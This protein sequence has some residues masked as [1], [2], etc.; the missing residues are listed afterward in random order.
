MLPGLGTIKL[1]KPDLFTQLSF[2][3]SISAPEVLHFWE[4]SAGL[5]P[6]QL[7]LGAVTWRQDETHW[8]LRITWWPDHFQALC[9]YRSWPPSPVAQYFV[10]FCWKYW[11]KGEVQSG[12]GKL[13][14]FVAMHFSCVSATGVQRISGKAQ[15][16]RSFK[17]QREAEQSPLSPARWN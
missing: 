16:S 2:T 17:E 9:S 15:G 6:Q 12:Q 3:V 1:K 14:S 5:F 4:Q 7:W 11:F 8:N 13:L 10:R